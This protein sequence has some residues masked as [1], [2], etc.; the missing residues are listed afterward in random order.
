V[1][2]K[3]NVQYE[4]G[5]VLLIGMQCERCFDLSRLVTRVSWSKN[6]I[7]FVIWV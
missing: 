4:S 7:C 1:K 5:Y 3:Q 2:I 6:C